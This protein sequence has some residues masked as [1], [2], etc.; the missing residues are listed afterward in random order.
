[1]SVSA[2]T[3]PMTI[4]A[5]SAELVPAGTKR[6]IIAASLGTVFEWYDFFLYGSLAAFF[7]ELF[8][9]KGSE[10]A[11]FLASLATFGAGFAVRPLG[12]LV[13]G[14]LGDTAGRKV[15]FLATIVLM[16]MS[17]A[18]LGVLPTFETCGWTSPAMLVTLRLVQGLAIGGEYGGAAIYVAEH[19]PRIRR[20]FATSWIQTTSTL[21]LLLS[22]AVVLACRKL[23]DAPD[24][25]QWGWRVPFLLSLVL[26]AISVYIRMKLDESPVFRRMEGAGT[27]S[28]TPLR[29]TFANWANVKRMLV[30]L[31]G[32]HAGLSVVWYTGQFYVLFFLTNTL[33]VPYVDAYQIVGIA[34]IMGA[35]L[36]IVFGWLS[37]QIGRKWI[38]LAGCGLAAATVFPIFQAITLNANPALAEFQRSVPVMVS[39]RDCNFNIFAAPS[40]PCDRA[41]DFLTK[42]GVSYTLRDSPGG[43]FSVTIGGAAVNSFDPPAIAAALK[44]AGLPASADPATMHKS[45]IVAL[46]LLLLVY[47]TMGYGPAAAYFTE[48]FPARIRYTSL[49]FPYHIGSGWFGGFLPFISAAVAVHTGN[50]YAGLWY[51]VIVAGITVIIGATCISETKDNDIAR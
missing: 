46:I 18:G 41:R 49:S 30:I 25:A 15:T 13:F 10:T 36:F 33:K 37:D 35:P 29:D 6:V 47:V 4:N 19:A 12:A 45:A 27:L 1:M 40:T 11:A 31:F 44:S 51:P 48:L 26:L 5:T 28:R 32:A 16:G 42:S 50:I 34:L 24:F 14:R 9:P 8:F 2:P 22:L 20:G 3:T 17:T 7:G 23:I 21:G 38:I 43:D 39:A